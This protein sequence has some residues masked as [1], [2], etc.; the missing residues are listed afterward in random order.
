MASPSPNFKILEQLAELARALAN[1]HRLHLLQHLAQGERS[2]ERLAELTHMTIGNASQHLQ[3]LRRSGFVSVQRD[4]KNMIYKLADGPI[5][6]LL[7]ALRRLGE[8]NNAEVRMIIADYF[9]RLDALEPV[10][11]DGLVRRVKEGDV[12]LLDVRPEDEYESGHLPGAL[13]LLPEELEKRISELPHDQEIVAY[14]RGAYCVASF[15][16]VA[17]LRDRGYKIRRLEEGF[18]EWKA[19]GLTIETGRRAPATVNAR[20]D[21]RRS[22]QPRRAAASKKSVRGRKGKN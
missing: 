16:V 4:G 22:K 1:A 19:A 8:S 7:T 11:R 3:Q 21:V 20:A 15:E 5:V 14:C 2:V 9:D 17:T 18:P 10:G 13:N 12:V 6:D